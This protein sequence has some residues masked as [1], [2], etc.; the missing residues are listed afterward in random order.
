MLLSVRSYEI[1]IIISS[2][3]LIFLILGTVLNEIIQGIQ[4]IK[5]FNWENQFID[6]I[7]KLREKE[8]STV[9]VFLLFQTCSN[10]L[11]GTLSFPLLIFLN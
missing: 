1:F 4:I 11:W 5:F 10:V 3:S 6:N 7:A 8:M 2:F 9:K